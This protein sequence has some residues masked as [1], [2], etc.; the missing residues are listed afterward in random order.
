[1]IFRRSVACIVHNCGCSNPIT[2]CRRAAGADGVILASF[3]KSFILLLLGE[4]NFAR[5]VSPKT[6]V[7]EEMSQLV[8][9]RDINPRRTERH[10]GAG[11]WIQHPT[12]QHDDHAGSSFDIAQQSA[13]PH[14]TVMQRDP[15]AIQR[16]PAIMNLYFTS[17]TGR[18]N[19]RLRL[20]ARMHCSLEMRSEQKTGR[21]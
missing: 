14:L 13:G 17:N 4:S 16:V 8:Q 3:C 10:V 18:M 19:G 15:P 2:S 11:G 21:C 7:Y 1:M 12:R 9:G 6:T 20:R 5:G